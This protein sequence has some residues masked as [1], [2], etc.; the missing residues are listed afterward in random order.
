MNAMAASFGVRQPL[1]DDALRGFC[2]SAKPWGFILF[3]EAC[4]SRAQVKRLCADLREA[5]GHDSV[6][7][8]DQEGGRVARLKAPEWPQWPP[9]AAYGALYARD[10]QAGLEA[11]KLGYRLIANELRGMG[12]D[13]DYA[14]VLDLPAP[15][16]DPIIGDRA[17]AADPAAVAALGRAALEG[18]RAGGVL[19]CVKHMPGHGRADA[20]SH[21]RLPRVRTARAALAADFAPFRA[22]RDAEAAMTAHI[23]YEA[24]DPERPAT[25]SPIIIQEIIRGEIGFDGL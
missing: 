24:L 23:L 13:A 3:R 1:M 15:G 12:V 20:D 11:A 8:I 10:R 7:H 2:R 22:L 19:G 25:H 21:L 5:S 9:A 14:P 18:L 17:F 6:I 16:G 4:V